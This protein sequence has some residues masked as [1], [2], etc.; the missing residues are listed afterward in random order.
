MGKYF[1]GVIDTSRMEKLKIDTDETDK[2][3]KQKNITSEKVK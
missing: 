3:Q 1:F 2:L